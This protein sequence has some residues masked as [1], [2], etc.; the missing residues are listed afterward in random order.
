MV[1]S[2]VIVEPLSISAIIGVVNVLF[3]SVCVEAI[4][5]NVSLA[6]AGNVKLIS[7]LGLPGTKV[8]SKLSALEPSNIIP[9]A[10]IFSPDVVCPEKYYCSGKSC[11]FYECMGKIKVDQVVAK[12][13][14]LLSGE[15]YAN[16]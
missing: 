14:D 8:V 10:P 2:N 12:S 13:L 4:P 15:N 1:A 5:A 16:H 6:V 11:P 7:A 3:V 9:V